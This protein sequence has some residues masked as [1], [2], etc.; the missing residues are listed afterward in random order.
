MLH[1]PMIPDVR[2]MWMVVATTAVLFGVL[3][4]WA[5]CA[6]RRDTSMVLWGC[7]NLAGGLGAGLLST[8]GVLPY[9]LSEAVANGFLV[10]VWALIW[11][12]GQAFAGRPVPWAAATSVPVLVTFACLVVPP[13]PTDIVLRIHL[14]SLSI[15]GYLVLIAVDSLRADR[16]ERLM[17]RRV[18]A[19]L[20][21][22]SVLPVIWRSIS[23]QLHGAPFELMKNTADTAMP[24]VGLFVMAI[25]IN[26]CLLL[27][28]RERLGNQ[29]AAAA[30]HD[31]LTRTL[32]RSG[33]LQSARQAVDE[34]QRG[35]RPCSVIVMD[36]DEFKSVNDLYGHAG[37]DRL[38]V[39]FA[40]VVRDNL[41]ETDLI[42]RIGGEEFCALLVDIDGAEAAVISERIRTAFAGTEFVH[43]GEALTATVS[44]GVAQIGLDEEL[45]AAI[46]RADLAMYRAKRD[47]RDAVVRADKR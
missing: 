47:G 17:T 38:L 20:A 43:A 45:A 2:T 16:A 5:G 40:A 27:I 6:G 8:Q 15:V 26:V 29:L 28:G 36:L 22:V 34:Y 37:G 18:L 25:A 31:G 42:G 1:E 46:R 12:G 10:L 4:V 39:G 13:L 9:A 32:N 41:R 7:A 3:E 33:F 35:S 14:T 11:A 24:L 21:I 30:T 19:T 44:M 23:A